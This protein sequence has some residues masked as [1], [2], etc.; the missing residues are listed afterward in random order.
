MVAHA[1]WF[2]VHSH[3]TIVSYYYL[4]SLCL[5]ILAVMVPALISSAPLP[6]F[7]PSFG[8]TLNDSQ[9]I[10]CDYGVCGMAS[11]SQEAQSFS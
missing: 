9:C 8:S 6:H 10:A 3:L 7:S 2:L 5:S 11:N 4:P 1:A